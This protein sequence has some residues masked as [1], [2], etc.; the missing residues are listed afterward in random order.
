MAIESNITKPQHEAF[1]QQS[2]LQE[3]VANHMWSN[4]APDRTLKICGKN[5][6]LTPFHS[7][8]TC[9]HHS[10]SASN[11]HGDSK[12]SSTKGEVSYFTVRHQV[13]DN[14]SSAGKIKNKMQKLKEYFL[15]FLGIS[16]ANK[17]EKALL[18]E[19]IRPTHPDSTCIAH[20]HR[21]ELITRSTIT[22]DAL[23][24]DS[25]KAFTKHRWHDYPAPEDEYDIPIYSSFNDKVMNNMAI[26]QQSLAEHDV[27]VKVQHLRNTSVADDDM[28]ELFNK[29]TVAYR[30]P[31]S[32]EKLNATNAVHLTVN[33]KVH[34]LSRSG[35]RFML[36][37]DKKIKHLDLTKA[38]ILSGMFSQ[39]TTTELVKQSPLQRIARKVNGYHSG[40]CYGFSRPFFMKKN[41]FQQLK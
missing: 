34:L 6:T 5:Y 26:R 14:L 28:T 35:V 25:N 9:Y 19:G 12:E 13:L 31:I 41:R 4:A 36:I 16:K 23:D 30:C 2:Q 33:E 39:A 37:S 15:Y 24:L 21:S 3:I 11:K 29:S 7:E 32:G 20:E 18:R 27:T 1:P 38:D 40:D 8:Q 17:I 10:N 22:R